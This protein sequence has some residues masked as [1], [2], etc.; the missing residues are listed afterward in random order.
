VNAKTEM[1][2]WAALAAPVLNNLV[3]LVWP[4]AQLEPGIEAVLKDTV[5]HVLYFTTSVDVRTRVLA[6]FKA[7]LVEILKQAP[8]GFCRNIELTVVSHSLGT[9]VAY[10]VLHDVVNDPVLGLAKDVVAANLNTLATP[11]ELIRFVGSRLPEPLSIPNLTD[12]LR[13]PT[14]T[15]ALGRVETNVKHWFSFRH[16]LDP[17]ASLA[18]LKG[19][20]LLDNDDT[21][22][23]TVL[24]AQLARV[25]DFGRY[26]D[27]ARGEIL[28]QVGASA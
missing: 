18:V 11:V 8:G 17:V 12:G 25:H 1:D 23:F 16:M 4:G 2:K 20:P 10:L 21:A 27:Q 13:R 15:N 3:K 6:E 7:R 22:P 9:V 26:V 14:R 5:A 24:D 19:R 28:G